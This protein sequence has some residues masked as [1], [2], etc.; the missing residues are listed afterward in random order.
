M[1]LYNGKIGIRHSDL[2]TDIMSEAMVRWLQNQKKIDVLRRGCKGT[3]AL[4]SIDSLPHKYKVEVYRRY[5]DLKAQAESK[6]FIDSI[7][8][9][10]A[11]ANYYETYVVDG[12]RGLSIDLVEK[13]TNSASILLAF[14]TKIE[15]ANAR[16]S[17]VSRPR[18][19]ITDFWRRAAQA[20]PRIADTYV[21]S[22]PENARRLQA[23]FNEFYR[24]GTTN[25]D[26][27]VSRKFGNSNAAKVETNEQEALIVKLLAD[28]RNFD[29]EQITMFYNIVAE[30]MGWE[31]VTSSAIKERRKKYAMITSAGRLGAT[32]FR[33]KISMQVKRSAPTLPMYMWSMDG[34]VAELLYQKRERTKGGG[35][36]TTYHNRLTIVVV[37]DPCGN[38]PVG[39][40][41]GE[42]ENPELIQAALRNAANHTAELF[43]RRYRVNQIQADR[44]A[45]KK[46]TPYYAVS[47]DKVTPTRVHNAKA[48]PIERYF[49]QLNKKYCQLMPNWAGFGITSN[50]DLQPNSDA[51][52]KH[53]RELPNRDECERQLIAIMERERA[54]KVD[55]YLAKWQ[56]L[57]DE[58][59]LPM[60]DEQYLL[61]Y[62]AET[63]HKN[64]LEGS[65][66]NVKLLGAKRSYDCFDVK[67]REYRHIRWNIKYDP[68]NLDK[69]LAVNDDGSVKFMLEA[70]YVQPMALVERTEE[71]TRQLSRVLDHGKM[72]EN[73]IKGRIGGYDETTELLFQ[74]NEQLD[75]TLTRLLICDSKGQHKNRRSESLKGVDIDA[76]EANV[77][78]EVEDEPLPQRKSNKENIFN[79]Y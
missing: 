28:H 35:E 60:T 42:H 59:K 43:G 31:P 53:R 46:M 9:D 54:A 47:G 3:P 12:V 27:L 26:V 22:L 50:R 65:G 76:V 34:W 69:V 23:K 29:S 48:K 40:A 49:G 68:E 11:A 15:I 73:D 6:E 74:R 41:I 67:F 66:V 18:L 13:Y 45:I 4:Y 19:K 36:R 16:R 38:Y 77:I 71:D 33:N 1:E 17:A 25:Y 2:T 44:Y 51:I 30:Q 7:V 58:R 52:N 5:P 10:G 64:A 8:I 75:T 61:T 14:K 24:G 56:E 21:H 20:L 55:E 78:E 63:G 79:L 57:P 70:K 72:L 39:Y 62:G 37:L 32:E